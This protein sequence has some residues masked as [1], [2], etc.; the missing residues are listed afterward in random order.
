L[1]VMNVPII[2]VSKTPRSRP[3]VSRSL[4]ARGAS[5]GRSWLAGLAE[6]HRASRWILSSNKNGRRYTVPLSWSF[7]GPVAQLPNKAHQQ[8]KILFAG[9]ASRLPLFSYFYFLRYIFRPSPN[10]V[11]NVSLSLSLR[12]HRRRVP[13]PALLPRSSGERGVLPPHRSASAAQPNQDNVFSERAAFFNGLKSKDISWHKGHG[14]SGQRQSRSSYPFRSYSARRASRH[15][16]APEIES[17]GPQGSR[18]F[19]HFPS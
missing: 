2:V 3:G 17:G 7:S 4:G 11:L 19:A 14:A 13:S 1:L 10:L 15:L 8:S 16:Q 6:V 9:F 5:N 12:P 18:S